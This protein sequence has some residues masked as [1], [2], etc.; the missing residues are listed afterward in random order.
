MTDQTSDN[1][2]PDE[3]RE[4]GINMR[5]VT[6]AID[7]PPQTP[8]VD[9]DLEPENSTALRIVREAAYMLP[10]VGNVMSLADVAQDVMVLCEDDEKGLPNTQ[11]TWLWVILVIDAV[12]VIPAAGNASRSIRAGARE[13]ILTF[14]RG[15]GIAIVAEILW[16]KA[17]GAALDFAAK[18]HKWLEQQKPELKKFI[19]DIVSKLQLL[20]AN[21]VDGAQQLGLIE[22]NPGFW[23]FYERGK[24]YGFE[25]FDKLI[26]A[27]GEDARQALLQALSDLGVAA[28]DM[29]IKAID[30]LL[31]V[32][33]GLAVAMVAYK[34]RKAN[35]T[36]R[37]QASTGQPNRHQLN[38]RRQQST[39]EG[40]KPSKTPA[41]C[42]C[43]VAGAKVP[44]QTSNHPI[45]Y[46]MGDENLWHTDFHVAGLMDVEWVRFYRSS[47]D[48]LDDSEL[49]ARWSTPYHQRFERHGEQLV[50]IDV[51]N[52]A[53]DIEPL[54]IGESRIQPRE[55]FTLSHPDADHYVLSYLNGTTERYQRL[56]T[57][58][59]STMHFRLVEQR[60]RDGRALTL[61]YR[62]GRLDRITD[63]AAL[64][65]GFHYYD[66][67]LLERVVRSYPQ[68][69]DSS[70][71]LH[72]PEVLALYAYDDER[73]LITHQDARDYRREY[74]YTHH[75][76]THYTNLNGQGV[77]LTW[78][79]PGKDAGALPEAREARCVRTR[80]EDGSED[81]RFEYHRELWYTRVTDA[82]G[83]VTIYRYNYHNEIESISHP[84][85][86]ELGSEYWQWDSQG[87]MV[88]HTDGEGRSSHY[89]YDD[90]GHVTSFTD[91]AGLTTSIEYNEQGLPVRV[92][93]PEGRI[94]ETRFDRN[95]LPTQEVDP[96]GRKTTFEHNARGLL[97]ALTDAAGNTYRYEWSDQGLLVSASDCSQKTTR[98]HYD[99]RG[100]LCEVVDAA[101]NRTHYALDAGGLLLSIQHADGGAEIFAHD[102]EGNLI[103][104]LDPAGHKTRYRYNA[105]NLLLERRDPLGQSLSYQYDHLNR[106]THLTN[107][108]G[109]TWSF[110]YDGSGRV[111]S[112]RGF[113][114]RTK[115]YQYD[116][117]GH[118][119]E[120]HE[121]EQVTRFRRDSFGRLLKRTTERPGMPPVK[122]DF[123]YD[124]L[125]R[126]VR[127]ANLDSETRFHFDAADNLVA[128]IQ[129]HQLPNGS[130]YRAVTRHTYDALGNREAT[131]LP[132]GQ[133]L[134]WLRYGSGHVHA[135][136]LDQQ[137]LIG[138]ERD[139]LHREVRRHHRGRE[140]QL[141]Y[142]PVGRLIGQ[143][144]HQAGGRKIQRQWHYAENGLLTAI[145]DNLRGT[146]RY[147]YDPLGRLKSA[148]SPVREEHFAFDPAGNLVDPQDAGDDGTTAATRWRQER[149]R[150]AFDHEPHE[151][152]RV[153]YPNAPKLSPAMGNL[154]KRYAGTHYHYDDFGNLQR[155]IA[156][157]GETWEYRYNAEHRLIEASRFA[158]APAAGDDSTP[159]TRAQYAYD[160]LGRRTYKH[161][162]QQHQPSELTV[163]TWDGDL[164]QSEERF[165]GNMQAS[166]AFALPELEPE[167]PARR[168]SLP[169]AQRQ[170]ML[171]EMPGII[172]LRRVVYLFE[173]DSFIPAAKLEAQYE[174]VAQATGTQAYGFTLYQLAQP[175]LYYF[176]TD[177]LGTPL[178]VT[179]SDGQLAWVGHYR[180]WGKL[181]KAN[182]G[183]N[184]QAA[185]E[186]PF[187][188]QGQYHDPETGLHYNRH[189]YYDPE[190]G[191]FT[192]QDP[193]GLLGGEN[194][195]QYAPNPTGWVDPLGLSKQ[196][197][198]KKTSYEAASRRD[199]LRQAKRDAGVPNAQQPEV[200]HT[201]LRD[202]NGQ[203]II[204][205]DGAPVM[206][207]EYHYTN[208][209]GSP[210][211]IQEHSL[212][213]VKAEPL[214]GAEPHFNVRPIDNPNTGH[215]PGTHGHYNF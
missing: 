81:T 153:D 122:T 27:F 124:A 175:A 132:D 190:I 136:A 94:H 171:T 208:T 101:G 65:L 194:L 97:T 138:F 22:S 84:F 211:M 180:A 111:L 15:E 196:C 42:A 112:E 165:Q 64:E 92:T 116:M 10:V 143:E 89:R 16:D 53:L 185:T 28:K 88:A 198:N 2:I 75:L 154:L 152:I 139:D 5:V 18:M 82:Q 173:P 20:V 19:S 161:V 160:A 172:P 61:S 200:R 49:G 182:D 209:D 70:E 184:R 170:Q 195:Y 162:E 32:V 13:A 87:R 147:G 142:D 35:V 78:E 80:L 166:R 69:S 91:S 125:G 113:D 99:H 44:L 157:N 63:G 79:W 51:L 106:P 29:V 126:L 193:I 207:R 59:D 77:E 45:D 197:C 12:G 21:P 181:E 110:R 144:V 192:T 3:L 8:N 117:A 189:R 54:A 156:P 119:A 6:E 41:N 104:Y 50:F 188:F 11:N 130:E 164:L 169:R 73:N 137:E 76:L 9:V 105:E 131:T 133:T 30:N 68:G 177:H 179:D 128:E 52:R 149:P 109:D 72:E 43:G 108:N 86:P 57:A 141:R 146:T 31:P 203:K 56:Q 26:E 103:E 85:N 36:K 163:F 24:T 1:N 90:Q 199:A 38:A 205:S 145:D 201:P 4:L 187:R 58:D 121:G 96:S 118:L 17:G 115:T 214:R 100:H 178:E 151:R 46:A 83:V 7:A 135:M 150:D 206:T 39:H 107:Q 74:C 66:N 174:A 114:G 159:L 129:H 212:G 37:A 55:R 176:Q 158:Q 25:L 134:S 120:M 60:E 168:F 67:G 210:V 62:N 95:G 204:G 155:R 93:D 34:T 14:I 33:V 167:D 123:A 23:D 40:R 213:H 47:I 148:I 140:T 191:R 71:T 48:Q 127:A 98:Y 102:G 202:G 186:N 215:V 183:N